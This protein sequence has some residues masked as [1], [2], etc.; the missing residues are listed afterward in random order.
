MMLEEHNVTRSMRA[1]FCVYDSRGFDYD[2]RQGET[3]VEL[4]EWTADGVKHN[5]MCRRSGDSPACVTNRSSSKFARRQVNCAMV[6]ANM[7]DIYKDLVN[8]GGGLKCLEAT[9][10]VFC[11]HGLKRGNQNPILILTHGDKLTAT[12]R[13]NARTKI[14]EV[15]GISETSGVYDIVCMT[16]HGVAAEECDPVTA[17]ALTEAVYRALLISDMSHTPK[18]NHTGFHLKEEN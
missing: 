10:Q 8:T 7:A 4:S 16:E 18:L 6:V 15:L 11:Y 9:K 12:D 17:Y 14:C 3:L 5:Q 1:G 13:M 2:D